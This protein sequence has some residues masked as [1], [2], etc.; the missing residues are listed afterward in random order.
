MPAKW[1]AT[2]AKYAALI[3][4]TVAIVTTRYVDSRKTALVIE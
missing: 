4:T 3:R 1:T 2:T